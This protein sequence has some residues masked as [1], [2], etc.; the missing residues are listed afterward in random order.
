MQ[1]GGEG[2]LEGEKKYKIF[3]FIDVYF[4]GLKE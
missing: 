3:D 1:D 2:Q 4:L